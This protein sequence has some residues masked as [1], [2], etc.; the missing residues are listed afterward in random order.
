MMLRTDVLVLAIAKWV[1]LMDQ[2]QI[3]QELELPE[4][5]GQNLWQDVASTNQA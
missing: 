2:H 1:E 3:L 5:E 4:D